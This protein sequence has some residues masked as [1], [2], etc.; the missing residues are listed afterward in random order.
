MKVDKRNGVE[1]SLTAHL[2]GARCRER[3]SALQELSLV[4]LCIP[5]S[6]W[7]CGQWSGLRVCVHSCLWGWL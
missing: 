5:P 1:E 3:S 6:L 4:G 7:V 2:L